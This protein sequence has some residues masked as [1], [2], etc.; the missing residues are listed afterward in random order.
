MGNRDM[1]H[2]PNSSSS[3]WLDLPVLSLTEISWNVLVYAI[4][5]SWLLDRA[6]RQE[7]EASSK[8]P[9]MHAAKSEALRKMLGLGTGSLLGSVPLNAG[10]GMVRRVS[11]GAREW[12]SLARRTSSMSL[13]GKAASMGDAPPGLG[14][15]DNSC[16]QNSVLQ[17]LSALPALREYLAKETLWEGGEA[18]SSTRA[19]LAELIGRLHGSAENGKTLWTPAKLKSMASWQ[20]QD[21]Q[22]YFS[23]IVDELDKEVAKLIEA[24]RRKDSLVDVVGDAKVQEVDGEAVKDEKST[25]P[26][27][28]L[29]GLLAQRVACTRCGFS[30]GLSMIPFNCL[31]VPLGYGSGY[32]LSECL[33]EYTKLEN[34]SDV[35]CAK[36]T[37]LATEKQL[38]KMVGNVNPNAVLPTP[39]ATPEPDTRDNSLINKAKAVLSLPPE[40][41][42]Q[43][44]QR[45]QAVET[46]LEEDNFDDKILVE[47]CQISKKARVSST[48][49]RQA[50]IGRAPQNLVIHVNRSMFDE[51]TGAQRKNYAAL[52]YPLLLRLG[53]WTLGA[54]QGGDK[55]QQWCMDATKSILSQ[56]SRGSDA[57]PTYRLQAVVTHFGRH[58]N[59]HYVAYRRHPRMVGDDLAVVDEEHEMDIAADSADHAIS[60]NSGDKWWRLSDEDV[61]AVSE[62]HLLNQGG[63]FMLFY[64]REDEQLEVLP[65]QTGTA[66]AYEGETHAAN[67]LP[68]GLVEADASPEASLPSTPGD[69]PSPVSE[70]TS[71][72]SLPIDTNPDNPPV[73]PILVPQRAPTMRTSIVRPAVSQGHF[74]SGLR[75]MAAT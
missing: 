45:L 39:E 18:A 33:D 31:T 64:E 42:L 9:Q 35:E 10:D 40:V 37:L 14:N 69:Q 2:Q 8:Q 60:D 25:G 13:N 54:S 61:T 28:P 26:Q 29:E 50:V 74:S 23:K 32:D 16:Y 48:K 43:I 41:R 7:L 19:S 58:E 67:S 62:Q 51:F 68:E 49:T 44:M 73:S 34:I 75:P 11:M 46:A 1:L 21:A 4:P 66:T 30:E 27:N 70:T 15:W 57:G 53:D 24:R 3:S 12:A 47:K 63:V 6:E 22:E 56:S 71:T 72:E 65:A 55:P 5:A 52:R 38:R 36:C 59:G 20:Q 17:G